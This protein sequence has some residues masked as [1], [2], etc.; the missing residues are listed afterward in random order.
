[1][2]DT[3]SALADNP[4]DFQRTNF[5][6]PCVLNPRL[7]TPSVHKELSQRENCFRCTGWGPAS[8]G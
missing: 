2:L 1:M 6:F 4:F 7:G 3:N 5:L 8:K